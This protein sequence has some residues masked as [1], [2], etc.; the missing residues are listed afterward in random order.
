MGF[1]AD[2]IH[3]ATLT[4]ESVRELGYAQES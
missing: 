4:I 1:Q 2:L 3:T